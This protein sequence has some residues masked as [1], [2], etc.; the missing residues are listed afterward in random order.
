[1]AQLHL[2]VPDDVADEIRERANAKGLTVSAFLSE[3]VR[4]QMPDQWP[5]DFFSKVVGGWSGPP[6]ERPEELPF[7]RRE[8]IGVPSRRKRLHQNHK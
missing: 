6:L 5:K 2:Y 3:I 7:D 8:A 4:R 1:M